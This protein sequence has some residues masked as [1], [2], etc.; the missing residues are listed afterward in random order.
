MP[1]IRVEI[2]VPKD[3]CFHCPMFDGQYMVCDLFNC[4]ILY[5]I[6]TNKFNRCDTCKKAEVKE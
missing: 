2:K 1:K 6:E 5:D 4:P 3:N